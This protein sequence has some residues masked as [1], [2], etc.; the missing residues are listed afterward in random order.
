MSFYHIVFER[1]LLPHIVVVLHH[2][3][4]ATVDCVL[5]AARARRRQ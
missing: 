5:T 2:H 3:F 4:V 1:V